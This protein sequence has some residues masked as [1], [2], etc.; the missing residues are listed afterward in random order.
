MTS[1]WACGLLDSVDTFAGAVWL[2]ANC[3]CC[4]VFLKDKHLVLAVPAL[5]GLG[6]TASLYLPI[7]I[8]MYSICC[9]LERQSG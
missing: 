6:L 4:V 3:V 9:C 5:H 2:L 7:S 8:A 1:K